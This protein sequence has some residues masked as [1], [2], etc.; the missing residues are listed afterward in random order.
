MDA[1]QDTVF[2][3]ANKRITRFVVSGASKVKKY[4][5]L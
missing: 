5:V 4:S 1:I 3:V 2:K